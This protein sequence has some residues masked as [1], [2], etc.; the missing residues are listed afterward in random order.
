MIIQKSSITQTYLP[1]IWHSTIYQFKIPAH[2]NLNHVVDDKIVAAP[3]NSAATTLANTLPQAVRAEVAIQVHP[4]ISN[5]INPAFENVMLAITNF[6][7]QMN[8]MNQRLKA[9]FKLVSPTQVHVSLHL[10]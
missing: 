2:L 6:T 10:R 8:L 4:A 3:A 7:N 5:A 1:T 9:F